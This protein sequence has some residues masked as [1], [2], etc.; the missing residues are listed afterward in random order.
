MSP[1]DH[2]GLR[3]GDV[4]TRRYLLLERIAW[5]GMSV[6]WRAF[7]QSLQRMVAVKMLDGE[8]GVDRGSAS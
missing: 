6:I 3:A 5:G 4:L 7:D 1:P 2:V 8:L